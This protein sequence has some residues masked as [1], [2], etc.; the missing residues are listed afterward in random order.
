M[1]LENNLESISNTELTNRID[2]LRGKEWELTLKFL[3]H[4]GEFDKRK[5]Y[6]ELGYPSLFEYCTKKLGYSEGSA[7]RRIESARTLKGHPELANSFINGKVSICSIASAAKAIKAEKASISDIIGKTSR[8]VAALVAEVAPIAKPKE[9]I[10]EIKVLNNL[11]SNPI[12]S[13]CTSALKVENIKEQKPETRFEIKFSVTK[14]IFSEIQNIKARLSNKLGADLS[15]ENIMVELIRN[16]KT[17]VK[18]RKVTTL[19][20]DTRYIPVSVKREVMR[21]ESAQCSYVSSNGVRCTQKHY[22]EFDHV[23]PFAIGGKS[24]LENIRLLCSAHNKAR[25]C[26]TFPNQTFSG[27]C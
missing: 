19:N 5:L 14:E 20:E 23:K 16:F 17:E 27:L 7:Y 4:L 24:N 12:Y 11:A 21:R 13:N 8:E 22:L 6:L 26:Q 9:K 25:V 10:K 2:I 3:I 18:E 15:I 1:N